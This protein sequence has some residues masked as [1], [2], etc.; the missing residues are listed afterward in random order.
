MTIVQQ[1]SD[2]SSVIF[3]FVVFAENNANSVKVNALMRHYDSLLGAFTMSSDRGKWGVENGGEM[4][5][6]E[7][8]EKSSS[9]V[10][11]QSRY[12]EGFASEYQELMEI[13]CDDFHYGP[14]IPGEGELK[15]LPEIRAG[16]RAL[17]LGCGGG[18]NSI[19]LARQGVECVAVDVAGGQLRHAAKLAGE[20]G[21]KLRLIQSPLEKLGGRLRSKFDLI[22]SSHA[23]EFVDDPEGLIK[24]VCRLLKP[25]GHLVVSTVHP[26]Y[27]GEWVDGFD[28]G[29]AGEGSGV[30]L[31]N[32][33]KPP[34]DVR[35]KGRQVEVVSRAYPVSAWFGWLR[36]AGLEVVELAELAAV[37]EGVVA[38]YTNEDWAAHD[39]M[40][41]AIPGTLIVVGRRRA[42]EN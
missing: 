32:Y 1:R 14:Q 38:P 35:Y 18:Q 4:G 5:Y 6:D 26:L 10:G 40:L 42:M 12:W 17:E 15:L 13:S 2:L 34:D 39:G 11:M 8:M 36:G 21:V 29:W 7:G 41:D 27:N 23:L 37:T 19:W 30:F 33:F 22:H 24:G 20:Y 3:G 9:M 16:M 25:G 28:E 31:S